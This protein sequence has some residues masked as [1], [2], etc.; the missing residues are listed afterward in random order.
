MKI[1]PSKPRSRTLIRTLAQLRPIKLVLTATMRGN[2]DIL[3]NLSLDEAGTSAGNE[4][5]DL[6]SLT[7]TGTN[8]STIIG[9]TINKARK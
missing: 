5:I 4:T 3:T 7:I 1:K 6:D 2:L 9:Y 8:Q